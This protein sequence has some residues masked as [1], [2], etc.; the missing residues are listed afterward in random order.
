[1]KDLLKKTQEKGLEIWRL[2]IQKVQAFSNQKFSL[3]NFI[4]SDF[5]LKNPIQTFFLILFVTICLFVFFQRLNHWI[6]PQVETKI[7]IKEKSVLE[8]R[9]EEQKAAEEKKQQEE[10]EKQ[11]S[12]PEDTRP[13]WQKNALSCPTLDPR[14]PA[15]L[16]IIFYDAGLYNQFNELILETKLPFTVALNPYARDMNK[17]IFQLTENGKECMLVIPVIPV[18]YPYEDNG[19]EMIHEGLAPEELERRIYINIGLSEK[20]V[21]ILALRPTQANRDQ[22]PNYFKNIL[23]YTQEKGF[24][25]VQ[26]DH[27][28]NSNIQ[29]LA[30]GINLPYFAARNFIEIEDSKEVIEKKFH[31]ALKLAK[32][33]G[34]SVLMVPAHKHAFQIISKLSQG[35]IAHRV[36]LIPITCI[37]KIPVRD[38]NS[39]QNNKVKKDG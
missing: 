39:T 31:M 11:F 6:N 33:T 5:F 15:G 8:E 37:G 36:T 26:R 14:K 16:A 10:K 2:F 25:Y 19:P 4:S 17:L 22:N 7:I 35:L 38:P 24:I 3:D 34:R 13:L 27:F 1:M 29:Q 30:Q 12:V 18:N 20:V 21:G 32:D 9:I 23:N 28:R